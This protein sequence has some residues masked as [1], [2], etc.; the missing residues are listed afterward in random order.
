MK[1]LTLIVLLITCMSNIGAQSIR[2]GERYDI[3]QLQSALARDINLTIT[4]DDRLTLA[5]KDLDLAVPSGSVYLI[6]LQVDCFGENDNLNP[7]RTYSY[8]F[9]KT[10]PIPNQGTNL[11]ADYTPI[12]TNIDI[13]EVFNLRV[14][15]KMTK[16]ENDEVTILKGILSKYAGQAFEAIPVGDVLTDILQFDNQKKKDR[17]EFPFSAN[18][19][20]PMNFLEYYNHLERNVPLLSNNTDQVISILSSNPIPN[21]SVSSKI[22]GFW[23]AG[24]KIITGQQYVS[25]VDFEKVSGYCQLLFSKDFNTNIPGYMS[26]A[27]RQ[28]VDVVEQNN[29]EQINPEIIECRRK[30]DEF[31]E[32]DPKNLRGHNNV[33]L[34]IDLASTMETKYQSE[35]EGTELRAVNK[36]KAWLA[37]ASTRSS[38]NNFTLIYYKNSYKPKYDS[39]GR[40]IEKEYDGTIYIPYSLGNDFIAQI[41]SFQQSLHDYTAD[42]FRRNTSQEY[43]LRYFTKEFKVN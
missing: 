18:Y 12:F 9:N 32:D 15:V 42:Y 4:R 6:D 22:R 43:Q 35:I 1:R 10:E 33:K 36:F 39:R 30:L 26:R 40:A 16:V 19:V 5:V 21:N 34:L 31:I 27:L 7:L 13:S 24:K 17:A 25:D 37:S 23:N 11:T 3:D 20:I 41:I 28:L 8:A 2:N 29:L 14:T 38:T